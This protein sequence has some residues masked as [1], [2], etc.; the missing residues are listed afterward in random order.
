MKNIFLYIAIS[1][2]ALTLMI[3]HI[4]FPAIQIDAIALMLFALAISPWLIGIFRSL[5]LPGG[6]KIEFKEEFKKIEDRAEQ[7]GLLR[8]QKKGKKVEFTF[9][10]LT[11]DD[12]RLALAGLRIEIEQRLRRLA[13][14]NRIPV[15]G[16]GVKTLLGELSKKGLLDAEEISVIDDLVA[17]LNGA[18]HA[19]D[20]DAGYA[21]WAFE[22]G[23]RL[24]GSLDF[25][26]K[27]QSQAR[28]DPK[29]GTH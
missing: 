1:I 10:Y 3:L 11:D 20:I 7:A 17:L 21:R 27:A 28:T 12:P 19:E 22:M 13:I 26:F 16:R 18:I 15:Q 9:Q 2:V 24:L 5:E 29:K 4:L 8:S 6:I 23:P 14:E 25:K